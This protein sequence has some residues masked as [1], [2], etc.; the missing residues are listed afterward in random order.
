MFALIGAGVTAI[1]KAIGGIFGYK[2]SKV[3]V[4]T[5]AVKVLS[6]TE[7]TKA[8]QAE[9]LGAM[10]AAEASSDGWLTRSWRPLIILSCWGII[11]SYWFG[12]APP[13]LL[14]ETVPPMIEQLINAVMVIL[15]AGIVTRTV[16]KAGA[17]GQLNRL[18]KGFTK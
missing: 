4:V 18:T 11:V 17:R 3:E 5:E 8:Q 16:D 14:D 9:A 13:H 2:R 15:T 6:A 10:M 12:Y 7:L 1:G